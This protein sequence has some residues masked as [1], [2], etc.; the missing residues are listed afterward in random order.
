MCCFFLDPGA[1]V[2]LS[3]LVLDSNISGVLM[4]EKVLNFLFFSDPGAFVWFE[5]PQVVRQC[6]KS[7]APMRGQKGSNFSNFR[8]IFG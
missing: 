5:P 3:Y 7:G 1:V 8:F 6:N 2:G 4:S